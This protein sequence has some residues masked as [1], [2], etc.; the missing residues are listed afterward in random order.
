MSKFISRPGVALFL[1][2][3]L[4][5][6]QEVAAQGTGQDAIAKAAASLHLREIGPA[7]AGGRIADIEVSPTDGSTW[8]VAVGSGGVW[9]TT[10]AG[11]TWTP[12]FD[13]QPSYSIG[14]IALDPSNPEVVW[15][16]TGENVSG[17]HVGWGDGVYRSR[18]GG[19]SW[20]QVGLES[21]EHIGKILVDPRDGNVVFVAAEG[22]LWSAGGER[23]VFRSTDGGDS[24]TQVLGLDEDT[25][26]TDL[27]FDPENPDVIYAA[28]FQRRRHIWGYM[29]GGPGSGIYKSTDGGD[30][31]REVSAGLPGGDI[32]KIGLAVTPADPDL[33]YATVEAEDGQQGFYR[34]TDKGERWV[35]R[36]GYTSGGTGPHYYQEIEASPTDPNL[37]YQMDVFYQVT[38]DGGAS[39]NIL[40]TGA[41]K[42]SDNHAIWI[43]PA[44]GQHLLGGTD[45][46]LY[47]SFDEGTTWRHFPNMPISQFYKVAMG[48][49]EPFYNIIGGAQDLGTL[50][51][52]SRTTNTEGVRNQDWYVPMGADGYNVGIDPT[53]PNIL[54][55]ETQQG[56]LY[57]TDRRSEEAMSIQPMAG[58]GDPP[59]RWN[60][61]SPLLI[62]THESDR[63]YFGSQ[64]V[65][66]SEDRGDSWTPISG[67]LTKD[68]NRYEMEYM[69]RVW[70]MDAM[71]DNG[72]MSQYATITTITESPLEAGVLYAGT[73]DGNIQVTENGGGIWYM[74]EAL[75]GVPEYSFINDMEASLHDVNSAFAA[76]DA[77][78]TGNYSP[79][80]FRT[81]DRGR[82]WTSISG[83]LPAGTI[84]WS[85]Q[86]DHV[87][88]DLIFLGTE[89]GIYFTPNGGTNWHMLKGGAPTISFRDIKIHRRDEDLVGAT[90][91][92]GFYVLDDY[93]P[94]RGIAGGELE[95]EGTLF[96]VRDAWWYIPN[97]PGQ[98]AGLP[99]QG[100]TVYTSPNPPFGAV[101]TYWLG[102]VPETTEGARHEMEKELR[103]EGASVPF[104]SWE[105]LRVESLENGPKVLLLV[106]D[107][108][109]EPVRWVE[110]PAREGLHRVNW[111]LRRAAPNAIRM[112]SGGFRAPWASDPQGPLAA[113]GMYQVELFMVSNNAFH[114][115]G[116]P[117]EFE[118]KPVP[119]APP[120]T[121]FAAVA[122]FQHQV[123]ELAREMDGVNAEM[124]RMRDRLRHMRL[125]LVQ[126]PKADPSLFA[127]VDEM[128]RSLDAM[129]L[130]FSGDRIRG[131]WNMPSVPSIRGRVGY[132][133]YGHWETRQ[134]PTETQRE[135]IRIA[136]RE[137]RTFSA[138]FR[139][140]LEVELV[141]LEADLAA[142]GAPW[143]P[144][145]RL[146][147]G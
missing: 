139:T 98:A 14:E 27:E 32:G 6:G 95:G 10:N 47:E 133:Q 35:R 131:Q 140:L 146:P 142:A 134:N 123:S 119:T 46:G 4:L 51:G 144:G 25:G 13:D 34:S 49:A 110:G 85:V 67:D 2:L 59:E 50:Y 81:D 91:G 88:P 56:N 115:M 82:S 143:T 100:S 75:P 39:F 136:E 26:A 97:A 54:Y 109:G 118:V 120:G 102:D 141:R 71:H 87:D 65:W 62:S 30:S 69:G 86:Q 19:R 116:E 36:N 117:Q 52:P 80:V 16:G 73:D 129:G 96:P 8:F 37:I 61:D 38:R 41:E 128:N 137:F 107:A 15:V 114:S 76:A 44:N 93:T 113:P 9:K 124:G 22:P 74:A 17:R 28:T 12:V 105:T 68:L 33:V 121:D 20:E 1:L 135:S 111:D 122:D 21:S 11:T 108:S 23:G 130:Q 31:W 90:F 104:P 53:D 92:R 64:R 72:A 60:W 94:L 127:R 101:I 89:Y 83:D 132:V 103:G 126:T 147:G 7:V 40:G 145:R 63:L 66:Q 24:W 42:H 106:R 70:S 58:P 48:N 45:A 78:K 57:R 84:V 112:A 125:A 55:M 18:D 43:D 79:Y 138:E 3:S 29:A 99:T 77:H 5:P